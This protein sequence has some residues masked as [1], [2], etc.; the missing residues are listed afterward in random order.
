LKEKLRRKVMKRSDVIQLVINKMKAKTYL[1]V[2]VFKGANFL[3]I[4]CK[5]K[6]AVDPEIKISKRRI[7][8]WTIKTPHNLFAEY[9]KLTSDDFFKNKRMNFK[10]D[11]VFIDGLHTYEQTLKDVVNSLECLNENGV[12]ILHDCNSP[13]KEAATPASSIDHVF[14]MNLP[15]FKGLWNGDV[16]K[17]ILY[18]RSQRKDL[19]TFVL[20]CDEG[21]GF[22]I[23]GMNDNCLKISE[24]ELNRMT[25]DDLAADKESLLN[26]KNEN[27][28][29]VFLK[30]FRE[31]RN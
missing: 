31:R 15:G 3:K 13:N 8:L 22:I 17:T 11:V 4:R 2:G 9:Y 1:E 6:V 29:D 5:K 28:L 7:L 19:K 10:F 25:Y 21:L 26:L 30:L 23:R 12:I 16:W 20:D 24:D 27:Y 18:L 14:K